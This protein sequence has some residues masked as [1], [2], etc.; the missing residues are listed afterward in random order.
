M[1]YT[2]TQSKSDFEGR[3]H[4]TSLN[5][6]ANLDELMNRAGRRVFKDIDLQES[7]RI[8]TLT[9]ALFDQVYDVVMPDDVKGDRIIDIR[10]QANASRQL[11]DNFDQ[12]YNKQFDLYKTYDAIN[13]P[14]FTV[15][16]NS[17]TRTLRLAK[18]AIA[19]KLFHAMNTITGNGTWA[20]TGT[21]SNLQVDNVNY[22]T[23][24][25]SLEFDVTTGAAILTNSTFTAIDMTGHVGQASVFLWLYVP[26][27]SN[28][29]SVK[30]RI[31]SSSGAYYEKTVTA[32]AP[33]NA[34]VSGWNLL[35]FDLTGLTPT[36][37]P[38]LTSYRYAQITV[39]ATA[40]N[41]GYRVD[42]LIS[43]LPTL[44]EMEYYSFY[45]FR[46]ATT[47]AWKERFTSNN[48]FLNVGPDS[49]ELFLDQCEILAL[50]QMQDAGAS[51]DIQTAENQYITDVRL[52]QNKY[53]SQVNQPKQRYY[54]P[55]QQNARNFITR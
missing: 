38:T 17:G 47:G 32:A 8:I 53:K 6:V 18:S 39:N 14:S 35:R 33:A 4:G 36:G 25:A 24:G 22:V 9:N 15:Q 31:G 49:Y 20:A 43:Q 46:D 1:S 10:P 12:R 45:P 23:G 40:N 7:I 55:F 54:K 44:Y 37:S 34:F 3:L 2:L 41:A 11:I 52:Y 50:R 16:N 26:N 48:D 13:K 51:V 19:G 28:L 30:L 21:G 27:A 29:T 42:N 5:K